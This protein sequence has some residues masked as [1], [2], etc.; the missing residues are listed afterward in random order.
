MDQKGTNKRRS[1]TMSMGKISNK[2]YGKTNDKPVNHKQ[3]L[4]KKYQEKQ[5]ALKNKTSN[6][7]KSE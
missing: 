5:Q 3:E 6:N 7:T 4:L 2:Q 1:L